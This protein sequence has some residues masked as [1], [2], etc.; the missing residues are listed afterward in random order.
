MPLD[1][2]ST[3]LVHIDLP[4]EGEWVEVKERLGNQDTKRITRLQF[5]DQTFKPGEDAQINM[6]A[7]I[8]G[9]TVA[10]LMVAI[11]RWSFDVPVSREAILALDDDSIAAINARLDELYPQPRT[12]S[13]EKNSSSPGATP[14]ED[15]VTPFQV[16]SAG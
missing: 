11:K 9:A 12:E 8:E 2:G 4:A 5:G 15:G 1:Y 3:N 16:S 13:D 6:G 7:V 10:R 14:S